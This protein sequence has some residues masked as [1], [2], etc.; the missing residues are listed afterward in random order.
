MTLC[1][2]AQAIILYPIW[3]AHRRIANE[4]N[5]GTEEEYTDAVTVLLKIAMGTEQLSC[6]DFC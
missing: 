6:S 3:Q 1:Y 5:R 2:K 4:N